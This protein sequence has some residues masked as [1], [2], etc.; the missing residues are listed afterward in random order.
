M[1][2][3]ATEKIYTG[4]WEIPKR[5]QERVLKQWMGYIYELTAFN[6]YLVKKS[7][8]PATVEDITLKQL[9]I[10]YSIF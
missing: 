7:N 9:M 10:M 2:K 5:I 6:E 8:M 1:S 4:I 3:Y